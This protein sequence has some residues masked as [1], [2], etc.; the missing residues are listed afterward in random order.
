MLEEYGH[1]IKYIK[2]HRNE[3]VYALKRIPLI[4]SV[5]TDREITKETLDK[6]YSVN[7]VER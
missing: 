7:I 3:A 6:M 5:A 4:N 1:N 2:R